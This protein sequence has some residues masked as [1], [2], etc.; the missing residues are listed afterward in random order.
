MGEKE[1]GEEEKAE[2]GEDGSKAVGE[3]R[4][5]LCEQ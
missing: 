1:G 2:D 5:D 4:S 3:S